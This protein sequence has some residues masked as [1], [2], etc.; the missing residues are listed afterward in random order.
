VSQSSTAGDL[1]QIALAVL[2]PGAAPADPRPPGSFSRSAVLQLSGLAC[3]AAALGCGLVAIW[4]YAS[5][6]LG[7]AGALLVVAA[8]LCVV[9]AV[10]CAVGLSAFVYQRRARDRRA[11]SPPPGLSSEI[12]DGALEAGGLRLFQQHPVLT[13]AAALLAGAL[14]GWKS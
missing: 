11:S 10:L 6:M 8:V 12:D 5:P 2:Q 7:A 14:L 3:I 13:L 1:F 4:I 9:A